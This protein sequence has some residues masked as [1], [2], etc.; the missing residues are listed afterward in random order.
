MAT[1]TILEQEE[2]TN[3]HTTFQYDEN[4]NEIP[5]T[6]V[7]WTTTTVKTQVEY[8]FPGYGK[9]IVDIAHF[10]PQSAVDIEL[11][12]NNRAI[13]EQKKLGLDN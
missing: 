6:E 10:N 11:G 3:H 12:I 4:G 7:E 1:F 9:H 13:T 5:G 2:T 8:D